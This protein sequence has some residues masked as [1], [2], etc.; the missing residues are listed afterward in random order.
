MSERGSQVPR[1]SPIDGTP[2]VTEITV[3]ETVPLTELQEEGHAMQSHSPVL[4][5]LAHTSQK[6]NTRGEQDKPQPRVD[7][8]GNDGLVDDSLNDDD[9]DDLDDDDLKMIDGK[10]KTL[11]V[12]L[13]VC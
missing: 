10:L 4:E 7:M 5:T 3:E 6:D 12:L 9:D 2:Q 11:R 1:F 13:S 8:L